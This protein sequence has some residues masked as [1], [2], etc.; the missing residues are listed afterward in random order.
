M[1]KLKLNN[2]GKLIKSFRLS[3]GMTQLD[4]AVKINRSTRSVIRYEKGEITPS[5]KILELIFNKS[6]I[7]IL[8][9][10]VG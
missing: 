2:I 5:I 4:L 6:I 1:K 9:E 8:E 7:E 3:Q 10:V